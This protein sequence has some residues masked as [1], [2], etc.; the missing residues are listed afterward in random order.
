MS[1]ETLS[2]VMIFCEGI[3][4]VTVRK[5]T[6]TICW[7]GTKMSVSPGPRT[8]ANFPSRNTDLIKASS[9][10]HCLELIREV[11]DHAA[12]ALMQVEELIIFVRAADR[13]VLPGS[14]VSQ[15]L[16]DLRY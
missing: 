1:I 3:C 4:I 12:G 11:R 6:R 7:I 5:D 10:A 15:P 8:P 14:N 16:R 13:L 9:E 2:F